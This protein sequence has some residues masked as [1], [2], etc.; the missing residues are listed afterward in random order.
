MLNHTQYEKI[1]ENISGFEL[2]VSVRFLKD[3]EEIRILLGEAKEVLISWFI[4]YSAQ[5]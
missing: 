1:K 3:L 4:E 2:P 5:I